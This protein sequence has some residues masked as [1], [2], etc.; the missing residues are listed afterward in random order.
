LLITKAYE[1]LN[2]EKLWQILMEKPYQLNFWKQYRLHKYTKL[3][4]KYGDGQFS[5][6]NQQQSSEAKREL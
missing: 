3:R 4:I 6:A 5:E 1:N 2:R